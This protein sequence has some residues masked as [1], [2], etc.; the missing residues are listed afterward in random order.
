MAPPIVGVQKVVPLKAVAGSGV[1]AR[2][3]CHAYRRLC[4]GGTFGGA[5]GATIASPG[6][7]VAE[8]E[9]GKRGGKGVRNRFL[10]AGVIGYRGLVRIG[11]H[12]LF[13]ACVCFL[14]T[15]LGVVRV[16][17]TMPRHLIPFVWWCVVAHLACDACFHAVADEVAGEV[18]LVQLKHLLAIEHP[19]RDADSEMTRLVRELARS[20]FAPAKPAIYEAVFYWFGV[21]DTITAHPELIALKDG[22]E[23]EW[24]QRAVAV[25]RASRLKD[26]TAQC[27]VFLKNR[28]ALADN[29]QTQPEVT[30]LIRIDFTADIRLRDTDRW[31]RSQIASQLKLPLANVGLSWGPDGR[32]RAVDHV[33]PRL[34]AGAG[35][36]LLAYACRYLT[37]NRDATDESFLRWTVDSDRLQRALMSELFPD[38]YPPEKGPDAADLAQDAEY[39]AV[40]IFD[41]FG[42]E[43][44][45]AFDRKHPGSFKSL[46]EAGVLSKEE[47]AKIASH[48]MESFRLVKDVRYSR[49]FEFEIDLMFDDERRVT[50]VN[51]DHLGQVV[52]G[53]RETDTSSDIASDVTLMWSVRS[54]GSSSQEAIEAASRVFNSVKLEGLPRDKVL[55]LIG[56]PAQRPQGRYNR[57]FWPAGKDDIVC[58]FDNG[59][60]GWQFNLTFDE[61]GNCA[62]VKRRWIH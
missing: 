61:T 60:Y 46:L 18:S 9:G 56:G 34:A 28:R 4:R 43:K 37:H 57:P 12:H 11:S 40:K 30:V 42:L 49:R 45:K 26:P 25:A 51:M 2:R 39:L 47:Q 59:N 32:N 14:C 20:T 7:P 8:G 52:D 44:M 48:R 3:R 10:A 29:P 62:A 23:E 33:D 54:D 19:D 58:R 50:T 17:I 22:L 16:N 36:L 24:K 5:V 31:S 6:G 21:D 27:I 41:H 1:E 55:E 35:S 38:L 13:C 53:N 15:L